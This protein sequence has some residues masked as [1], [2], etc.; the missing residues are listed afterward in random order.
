[1][2]R[3]INLND[4]ITEQISGCRL[5]NLMADGVPNAGR[6]SLGICR[7]TTNDLVFWRL[8][9]E[10]DQKVSTI[11]ATLTTI[12]QYLS[13]RGQESWVPVPHA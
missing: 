10:M 13:R 5:V 6:I 11:A 4:S 7:V 2:R 1:M 3:A 8:V 12:S 9:H